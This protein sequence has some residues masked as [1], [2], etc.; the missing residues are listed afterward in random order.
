M[1]AANG[2][3]ALAKAD[4]FGKPIQLLF[5]DVVM[6]RMSGPELAGRIREKQPHIGIIFTSGFTENVFA[7]QGV[8][9]N[10]V[11]LPKPYTLHSLVSRVREVIAG[12]ESN[13]G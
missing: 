1:T 13:H 10:S 5:T 6:P 7:G 9:D 4:E 8:P 12:C 2:E 11:F 3:E